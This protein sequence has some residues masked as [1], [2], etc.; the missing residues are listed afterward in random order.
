MLW[1][2]LFLGGV[3]SDKDKP[4]QARTQTGVCNSFKVLRTVLAKAT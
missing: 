4:R 1:A 3:S 2:V